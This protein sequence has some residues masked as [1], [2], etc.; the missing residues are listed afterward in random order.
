MI[1][2]QE[3][4]CRMF[5]Q[6]REKYYEADEEA[7]EALRE[8]FEE[9]VAELKESRLIV[10][11]TNKTNCVIDEEIKN[12]DEKQR[13]TTLSD[14]I[15][16]KEDDEFDL[17]WDSNYNND[18]EEEHYIIYWTVGGKLCSGYFDENG[19]LHRINKTT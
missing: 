5:Q 2:K 14:L 6:I 15:S 7:F 3:K 10:D 12:R 4:F 13:A 16:N 11:N 1:E 18:S 17:G 19:K 8:A 9:A